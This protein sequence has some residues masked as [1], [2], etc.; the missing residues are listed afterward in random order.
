MHFSTKA[1]EKQDDVED[2]SELADIKM[3]L[4]ELIGTKCRAP[5][6]QDW[7]HLH[8]CN[9]MIWSVD[10]PGPDDDINDHKVRYWSTYY[11]I[12]IYV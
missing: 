3:S 2:D 8:Y 10:P 9:A 12:N 4:M 1:N 5:Y 7:G 11:I 6:A